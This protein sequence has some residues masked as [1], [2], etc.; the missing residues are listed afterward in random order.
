MFRGLIGLVISGMFA[1]A[2]SSSNFTLKSYDLGSGGGGSSSSSNYQLNGELG[3]QGGP[4]SSSTNYINRSGETVTQNANVPPAPNLSNPSNEYNRLKLVISTGGNPSD[5]KFAIAIS[6]DDFV[7]TRYVKSDASI[8][9]TLTLTDYKV[10][11][12]WGGASGFWITGL[13]SNTTYKVKVK[14]IQGDFTESAY[15]PKTSGVATVSPSISFGLATNPPA[16]PPYSASFTGLT[17]GT[18][19]TANADAVLSLDTNSLSGGEV[20]VRDSNA[21]L[22]SSYAATTIVSATA[23]LT[24][25][26]SGYGAM[27]TNTSQSS[28]GPLSSVSPFDGTVNNVGGLTTSLQKIANTSNPVSGG[29]ITVQLKAKST[30]TTPA[31]TDYNDVITFIA[32][33]LY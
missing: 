10:Y 27:V 17:G 23:D 33:M 28:G 20:F 30:T 26:A 18:V 32:A 11:T 6:S 25:A 19:F 24:S 21:G 1:A 15:G 13:A 14:A 7:T 3:A 4:S 8:G 16:G 22:N 31:A 2:P 9:S 5:T 12:S 29:S